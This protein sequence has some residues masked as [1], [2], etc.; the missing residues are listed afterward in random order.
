MN[1]TKTDG[2][3]LALKYLADVRS[4]LA[5]DLMRIRHCLG[6]LNESQV[7]WRP[8]A[9]MNSIGNLLLHLCGN[10]RWKF[11]AVIGGL[12][13]DRDRPREFSER[14][15]IPKE[16]LLRR[17]EEEVAAADAA[18]AGLT[19]S[20]LLEIRNYRMLSGE[21]RDTV[22]LVVLQTVLHLSGHAQEIIYIT[23]LQLGEA[24]QFRT[25][26]APDAKII[27]ADDVVF[28]RGM[29]PAHAPGVPEE[30]KLGPA[31]GDVQR[32]DAP[33][34]SPLKDY[35]LDLEQEFQEQNEEGKVEP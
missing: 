29:L 22:Q 31:S 5:T 18:L 24:Y 1:E 17:L 26:P 15:P 4:E 34:A 13:D 16:E 23:R 19:P 28:A 30:V 33:E 27:A 10:L 7:W 11:R 14:G 9:S 3:A 6:Q 2:T 12:P 32:K 25:P 21:K 35:L 20:Q 8:S